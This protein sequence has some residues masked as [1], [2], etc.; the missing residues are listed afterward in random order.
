[1]DTFGVGLK[2]P[3][4]VSDAFFTEAQWKTL[5]ALLDAIV[6]SIAVHDHLTTN[7][8]S[9][10]VLSISEEHFREVYRGV[11]TRMKYPPSMEKFREYLAARPVDDPRFI[12]VVKQTVGK[13]PP[14]SKKQ[15]GALLSFMVSVL[16]LL[17]EC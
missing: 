5:F 15:L 10:D 13:I 11:Q 16:Y 7:G 3:G 14:S 4:P 1:M 2:I 6:P 17:S 9:G 8:R 12:S